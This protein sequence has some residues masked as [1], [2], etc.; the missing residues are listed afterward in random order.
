MAASDF[1]Y[2]DPEHPR[3]GCLPLT[4]VFFVVVALFAAAF[5]FAVWWF[6]A[7]PV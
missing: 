1:G 2:Q 7:R 4:A 6:A 5:L 3:G